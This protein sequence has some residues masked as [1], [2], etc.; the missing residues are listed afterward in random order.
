MRPYALAALR[1]NHRFT[2]LRAFAG[3]LQF[4]GLQPAL[5]PAATGVV[6]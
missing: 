4:V 1:R 3:T 5:R 6:A 2:N